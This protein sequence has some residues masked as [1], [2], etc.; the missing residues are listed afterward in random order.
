MELILKYFLS[1]ILFVSKIWGKRHLK[2]Y[3]LK[4]KIQ[5]FGK[6]LEMQYAMNA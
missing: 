6:G 4:D 5:K 2:Q 3:S 1:E